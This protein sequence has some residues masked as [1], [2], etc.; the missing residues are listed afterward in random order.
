ME[1][2]TIEEMTRADSL[3]VEAGHEVRDLMERAG[4]AVARRTDSMARPRSRIAVVCGP[5]NNGG[6]GFVAARKLADR[7][8]AVEV[9]ALADPNGMEGAAGQAAA[10][11]TGTVKVGASGL[12]ADLVVDAMFG[13]GLS[14]PLEGEPAKLV[15]LVNQA[16]APVVAV[17]VPSGLNGDTGAA[18]GPVVQAS[19][20]VTFFREKPGHLLYP[21]RALCGE[22]VVAQIGI[23]Q[24]GRAHV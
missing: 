9:I 12:A 5:G 1:L 13:A 8:H 14:R 2:L 24:I 7:G 21:G 23:P 17:D 11:W 18:E 10:D 19:S 22:T 3:A 16:G 15:E 4:E 20:T 6:D